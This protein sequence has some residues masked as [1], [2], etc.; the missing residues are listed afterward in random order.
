MSNPRKKFP[1]KRRMLV[2]I[3]RT[4]KTQS[5]YK[6]GETHEVGCYMVTDF[7][8]SD[9]AYECKLNYLGINVLDC[10][11]IKIL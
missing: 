1:N 3:T 2:K 5:W 10:K 8:N 7:M 11:I 9:F 4:P 6:K